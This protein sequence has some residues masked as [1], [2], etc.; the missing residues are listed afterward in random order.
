MDL[1]S[2]R[3]HLAERSRQ[4]FGEEVQVTPG[5]MGDERWQADPSRAAFA[6]IVHPL[7]SPGDDSS[8]AGSKG[9]AWMARIAVGP[10]SVEVDFVAYPDAISV[11]RKDRVTLTQRGETFE[12]DRV[13]RQGRGR[14]V[15]SLVRL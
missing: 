6:A 7:F 14:L 13:D 2:A 4:L 15:W 1:A 8:L 3:L 5:I 9:G 12:I 10:A 11:R